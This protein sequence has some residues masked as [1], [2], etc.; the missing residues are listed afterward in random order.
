MEERKIIEIYVT[1]DKE[2][3]TTSFNFKS[4]EDS[5]EANYMMNLYILYLIF[6]AYIKSIITLDLKFNFL[7]EV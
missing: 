7:F 2:E 6:K 4:L 3:G 5:A 1:E